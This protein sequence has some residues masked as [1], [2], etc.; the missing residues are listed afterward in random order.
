MEGEE[1]RNFSPPHLRNSLFAVI[2]VSP[3][4]GYHFTDSILML[5]FPMVHPCGYWVPS[6]KG[7][8]T[9]IIIVFILWEVY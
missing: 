5:P 8:N 6:C 7:H 2:F 3:N 4:C 1:K 9:L